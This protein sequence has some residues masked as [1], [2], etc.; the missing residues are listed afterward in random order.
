[1]RIARLKIAHSRGISEAEILFAGHTV[2][3]GGNNSGKSTVLE[4]LDLVLG[5]DRLARIS[6][7]DEHDFYASRYVDQE[8]K[9][10]EITIEVTLTDLIADQ[11]R[12][13]KDHLEFWDETS[14]KVI[15]EPP[16]DAIEA[17]HVKETLRVCFRGW[18]SAEDDEFK[19][20][21]VFCNPPPI[22]NGKQTLFKTS[23][24]RMCGFLYL[25]S[26]R[27]GA[28]ALSLERGSLLDIILRIKEIRPKMWEGV[29]QQL[30]LLP[31]A[32]TAE[33]GVSQVLTGFESALREF[34][35]DEWA[36]SPHLRVSD[37]TRD[38]LRRTLTV[39]MATGATTGEG[40]HAA[41][42]QNQGTGTTNI[43]VLALLS[44]IAEEKKTVIFAMEEPETAI[45][46]STQKSIVGGVRKK[47]SQAIFTSHSP[48]VLEEFD[49]NQIL[50]LA[51]KS[52]GKLL[53]KA[54]KF[55]AHIKPKTYSNEFRTRFAE[56]LLSRRVVILE[57]QTEYLA[58]PAAA[59]RL[60]ELNPDKYS[61]LESLD[62]AV[63]CAMTDSQI[64]PCGELF[65]NLDKTVFAVYDRQ[66]EQK[67]KE[68]IAAAVD[69]GFEADTK[70]FES[71]MVEGTAESA[72]RQYAANLVASGEWPSH[73]KNRQPKAETPYDELKATMKTFFISGG[74]KGEGRAADLLVECTEDEMPAMVKS[75]LETIRHVCCPAKAQPAVAAAEA[76]PGAKAPAVEPDSN[77]P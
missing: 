25:R 49:P 71:L 35:P 57:G 16:V 18:Y 33:D 59:H 21:T 6:P 70:G 68:E 67:Q 64:A 62:L 5:P 73:L 31:V 38:H 30:R 63:F 26:L 28:R 36:S 34:V 55:P 20:E 41:P 15:E 72:L 65:R 32:D 69:Y 54:V 2:L 47:S 14:H 53:T 27:T 37:L 56:V 29:L 60:S 42:F 75:I 11:I 43:L 51:R 12:H 61:S 66:A 76:A 52:D 50:V 4:A 44:M 22:E 17:E 1:M 23:D 40:P 8:Q 58:Y 9:P 3:V 46:P 39:F 74:A 7:I 48:Y 10:V 13:F 45:S 19:A 77:G 24:K